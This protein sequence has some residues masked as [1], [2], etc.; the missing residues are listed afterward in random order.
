[1]FIPLATFALSDKICD[2][3]FYIIEM[4]ISLYSLYYIYYIRVSVFF[5]VMVPLNTVP[6]LFF[7]HIKFFF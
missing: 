2:I 4:A 1:M 7:R 5:E 6:H 3:F